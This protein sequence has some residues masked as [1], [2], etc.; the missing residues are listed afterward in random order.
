M[1]DDVWLCDTTLRDGEQAPG[2]A[3]SYRDKK[4][5]ATRLAAAG[6]DELEVGVPAVGSDELDSITRLVNLRLPTRLCSWNRAVQS[7]LEASFRTGVQGV[8]ISIPVS[9]QHL[10]HKLKKSRAWVLEQMGECVTLA[11]KEG[12]YICVGLED[13]S[14]ADPDFLLEIGKEAERLGI[15][16]IRVADTLG[17]LDPLEVYSRFSQLTA[18]IPIPFEFH[19]HNDLGMA[20]ANAIT[21][22][23]AGFKAVSVTVGGLGERAGNAALEEVAV[24]LKHLL[25]RRISFDLRQVNDICSLVSSV[26]HRV[27]P[28]AKPIVG[29]DVFTHTSSVHLDGIRKDIVNYQAFPLD[30][31]ARQ[32]SIAFGKYSGTKAL[33]EMLKKEGVYL[34]EYKLRE[35]LIRTRLFSRR[36]QTPLGPADI[37]RLL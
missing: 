6:I 4:M 15:D 18:Q 32:H 5:I 11:Q 19:A 2:V 21:A 3:F 35:L 37:L 33:E 20:T 34:D 17:I 22:V 12:K 10:Q 14:R 9:D 7:D 23:K 28:R 24:V 8:G 30:S 29:D 25:K 27:I 16:R 31:I 13:A 36:L 1:S 26:T